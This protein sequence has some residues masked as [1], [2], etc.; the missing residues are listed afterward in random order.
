MCAPRSELSKICTSAGCVSVAP[1]PFLGPDQKWAHLFKPPW[2]MGLQY[3]ENSLPYPLPTKRSAT[4][5]LLMLQA[6]W[7]SPAGACLRNTFVST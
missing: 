1:C 5:Q 2:K 7:D 3:V 4:S 6:F